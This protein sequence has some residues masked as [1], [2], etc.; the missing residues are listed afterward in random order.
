MNLRKRS[1]SGKELNK[2]REKLPLLENEKEPLPQEKLRPE[3]KLNN[4]E[5]RPRLQKKM[6]NY[7]SRE[8]KPREKEKERL[9]EK[10]MLKE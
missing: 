3:E 2:L 5:K 1:N 4:K 9:K 8:P 6:L 7:C 10:G